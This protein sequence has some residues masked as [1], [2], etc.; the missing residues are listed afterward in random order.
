MMSKLQ[1][2]GHKTWFTCRKRSESWMRERNVLKCDCFV[3][4]RLKRPQLVVV[5][6]VL[7][8]LCVEARRRQHFTTVRCKRKVKHLITQHWL[9]FYEMPDTWH[10]THEC[11]YVKATKVCRQ[12]LAMCQQHL[13]V[14][15]AVS[16]FLIGRGKSVE[17]GLRIFPEKAG[18]NFST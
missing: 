8:R 9:R 16:R 15:A 7:H 5:K 11:F 6:A 10:F 2:L 1:C 13:G 12:T 18:H 3:R 17:R 14:N 4:R